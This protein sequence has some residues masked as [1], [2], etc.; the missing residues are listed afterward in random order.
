MYHRHGSGEAVWR[1]ADGHQLRDDDSEE[2]DCS[3]QKHRVEGDSGIS[4]NRSGEDQEEDED[5]VADDEDE[6]AIP[7]EDDY[8]DAEE[9]DRHEALHDDVDK[10][11][12]ISTCIP[13]LFCF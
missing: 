5:T 7:A 9:W 1:T 10:Q 8:H 11:V 13:C 12:K 3:A 6:D 2:E 4:S